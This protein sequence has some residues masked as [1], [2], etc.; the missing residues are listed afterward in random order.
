[1]AISTPTL[2]DASSSSSNNTTITSGSISPTGDSLLVVIFYGR[3]SATG[4]VSG[5]SDTLSGTGTWTERQTVLGDDDQY[6]RVSIWTAQ[7]GSSPGSGTITVTLDANFARKVMHT[8]EVA[9]GFDTTTPYEQGGTNEGSS[10][11]LSITLGASPASDSLVIGGV[12]SADSPSNISPGSGYTE[13]TETDPMFGAGNLVAECEYDLTPTSTTV[14][15]SGLATTNNAGVAIEINAE[16]AV[17]PVDVFQDDA[18]LVSL[19]LFENGSD[20]GEDSVG[21]N[22]LTNNN[23][24][25]QSSDEQEGDYSADFE[26]GSSQTLSISDGSQSG[27]DITGSI[28]V[29]GWFKVE[30]DPSAS[31]IVLAKYNQTGDNRSYMFYL[32]RTGANAWDLYFALS[33]DGAS[34]TTDCIG[35]TSLTTGTWYH[36]VGVYDGTDVRVYLNGS[37]D[38]NGS[39]NPKT[40]SSGIYD[41]NGSFRIGGYD[42][43]D[44][45]DF[46]GLM[47]E[48]FVFND[49]LTAGE[50][51][52]IYQSGIQ[53]VSAAIPAIMHHRR[54][55]GMS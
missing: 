6:M 21:A 49:A 39:D 3:K 48:V 13:L 37:L 42:N 47:D 44:T 8:I 16:S 52:G 5:V 43:T 36:G 14:D 26:N 19:W 54:Q 53:P 11:T 31:L 4:G 38:S 28:S 15:W 24:V 33:D 46:D 1:M 2:L 45:T 55:Q 10:S 20:L 41:G 40:Y 23:G 7:A 51:L 50:V 22:D 25:T 34:P 29:G 35:A 18:N 17:S 30:D 32:Y 12:G 27:L 9:S